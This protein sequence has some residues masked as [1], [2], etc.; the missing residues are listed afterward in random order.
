MCP[1]WSSTNCNSEFFAFCVC[2]SC[3]WRRMYSHLPWLTSRT[4]SSSI[5]LL[6][7]SQWAPLVSAFDLLFLFAIRHFL[8]LL[9]VL[10]WCCAVPPCIAISLRQL[11]G[12][13]SPTLWPVSVFIFCILYDKRKLI[14]PMTLSSHAFTTIALW[15]GLYSCPFGA[16]ELWF[17]IWRSSA[18]QFLFQWS[19]TSSENGGGVGLLSSRALSDASTGSGGSFHTHGGRLVQSV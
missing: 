13:P 10:R 14:V 5:G 12:V 18:L 4:Y 15:S 17:W 19:L 16:H 2:V 6:H 11:G 9:L 1:P 8:V 7:P 3:R